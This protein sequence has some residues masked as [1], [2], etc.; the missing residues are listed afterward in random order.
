[1]SRGVACRR[2]Y[3]RIRARVNN[4]LI[5]LPGVVFGVVD[6]SGWASR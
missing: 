1:M 3:C 2:R 4:E 5:P 6:P